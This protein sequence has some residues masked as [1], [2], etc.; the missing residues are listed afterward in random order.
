MRSTAELREFAAEARRALARESDIAAFEIYAASA[1]NR[2]ARISYT[3]DI[4]CRGVEELKT[5]HADGFQVRIVMRR[6]PHEVGAAFD[7][8]D[9]TLEALRGVLTRARRATIVDPHF[10]G[11]APPPGKPAPASGARDDLSRATDSMLA[12]CAWSIIGGALSAFGDSTAANTRNPGLVLGG[13]ISII[14]DR[15]AIVNSAFP[16]LRTDQ[17]AHFSSSVTAIVEALDAKG[18]AS[19]LGASAAAMRRAADHLGGDAV[20]GALALRG[21]ERP[22]SGTYRVILGPQPVAEILNYMVMG[23]LT[24]GAFHT[25]SSAY[26][27]RFGER[28]MDRGLTLYDDPGSRAGAVRRRITCEGLPAR[29]VDLIRD[30]RLVGLLST[31]YDSHRL[32]TDDA[33]AEKLGALGAETK[34]APANAYRLGEGGGRRFDSH[35]GSAGT[36]VIMRAR[37]GISM[38]ELRRAVGDGIHVGRVWY[39]YPIN[40][41]RAGDFTCTI[42][43]DSYLLR[44][45]KRAAALAPN[46]LRINANLAQVFGAPLAAS[47]RSSPQIVWGAPEAFYVP[48]L[49][50]DGIALTA[51][52]AGD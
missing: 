13:D 51:V 26:H 45:G 10:P 31:L 25:S 6:D 47:A 39:T 34:F 15:I 41:Q 23:S 37:G 4:P 48:A 22:P 9:F 50:V 21:G 44:G 16:E 52:G 8:G 30:G 46:C 5:L 38:P 24:T 42:S 7:A 43:G 28:V 17:S 20:A 40:G 12:R 1:E 14:R 32:A 3:S 49:A 2:I 29:R 36:N 33:R 18:T 19:E 11:L 35:P 27:G